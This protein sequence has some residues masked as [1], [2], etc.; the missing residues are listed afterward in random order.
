MFIVMRRNAGLTQVQP[1]PELSKPAFHSIVPAAKT[2][3]PLDAV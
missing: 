1:H 3:A 2:R